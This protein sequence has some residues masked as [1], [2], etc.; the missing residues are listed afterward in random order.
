MTTFEYGL[1]YD[2]KD[3]QLKTPI[4]KI[5]RSNKVKVGS[6]KPLVGRAN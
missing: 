4:L 1:I 6:R 3:N 5:D 2:L